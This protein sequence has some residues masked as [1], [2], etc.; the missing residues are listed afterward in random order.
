MIFRLNPLTSAAKIN[1][2]IAHICFR[3]VKENDQRFFSTT[4]HQ[5]LYDLAKLFLEKFLSI[6]ALP[7]PDISQSYLKRRPKIAKTPKFVP[8]LKV[9]FFNTSSILFLRANA[10]L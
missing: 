7:P 1:E 3:I 8:K 4:K 5:F 10:K 6:S 9:L 2:N